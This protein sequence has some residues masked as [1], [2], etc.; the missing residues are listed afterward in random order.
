MTNKGFELQVGLT[1]IKMSNG[2]QWDIVLNFARNRNEVKELPEG[3]ESLQLGTY[4]DMKLLAI[5]GEPY[6]SFYGYD[7]E[8]D[9]QGNVIHENGLPVQG[10]LT[11]LGSYTPDFTG[12]LNNIFTFKGLSLNALIDFRSGGEIYSMSTTWGRYAGVLEETLIGREGGIVGV[13]VKAVDDGSG[14]ISYVPNDVV[15]TCE[16][17]NKA[18]YSNT[19]QSSSVFD[20]SFV[21]L[22][23]IG[24]G[25]TFRKIGNLPI[26]DLKIA[27]IG[28]NLALL[29]SS[30]PHIDPETAFG[31]GNVQGFEFGQLPSARSLGFSI[32]LGL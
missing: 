21:K 2:L 4:W 3:I 12:G 1:P 13:G 10:D 20:A 26:R 5:P 30:V 16:D 9:P 17:Y 22:R 28:R 31:S 7:F 27:L 29:K 32:S 19:L 11:L 23:E 8:R 18:A 25:Y 6:G 14:N 15:A 24:L